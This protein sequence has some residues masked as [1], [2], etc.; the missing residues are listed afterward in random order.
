MTNE[1]YCARRMAE[2]EEQWNRKSRQELEAELAAYYR[3]A[4][5]HI[6]KDIDALYARFADDNGLTYVE[7]SQLLQGSEYRVWRMDIE[8]YLK[9]YKDTG[10]KAILQELNILAM[11]SRIT[12]LDKLYT[13]TLVHLADLTKKAEDAIDKYF[14]TVY[15][16]FY[17]HSLYDIGQKIGLRAAVTAVDD[18][19]VLSIL[20]TPWN[21]KN[22]S[23]RIWKDNAQLGKA[24]KDVVTQA[25]HRGTDIETLS[26]LVSRRMDVG[27]SNARRLV[28]TELNFTENRAAFDSIKEAG[29]KYY[30]FSATLDRRTSATCRDHDGRVY[31]IDEYQPGSTAPPLHPNCRSTIAGSLYGPDK[32][33]TGTRIARNDKGKTYY[34][35]ADM[36]YEDW[37]N[38]FVNQTL[39]LDTWKTAREDDIIKLQEVPN[40]WKL[41]LG[42]HTLADDIKAANPKYSQGT[43][44]QINCQR[45]VQVYEL[46]QRG[47]DV[48]AMPNMGSKDIVWGSECFAAPEANEPYADASARMFTF[49]VTEET[50]KKELDNAPDGSRYV[51]YIVW[52]QTDSA[53]VFI[54]QKDN[55]V[56]KYLDPQTGIL[57]VDYYFAYGKPG[58]FGFC[59]IDDKP[60]ATNKKVLVATAKGK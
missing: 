23:Q 32:K 49:N 31:S 21:G 60:L 51:I 57:D 14:P 11:R 12:R 52:K 38:I 48:E 47:F 59:R 16:D 22:Y 34:V 30:C 56:I 42:E 15:Q 54:A 17:Y 25:T 2:L 46:R 35:P 5:T 58:N 29:M 44:Y 20:K 4:L 6:Q 41:I 50:I 43:E 26:R 13:E 40:N 8:D 55:G 33:K 10:D 39:S 19:Q 7:A 37:E 45:C 18:K 9:Q 28:R 3:Q 1:E 27:V 36:T 53:H 24:I